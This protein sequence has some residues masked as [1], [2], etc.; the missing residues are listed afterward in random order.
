MSNVV[1]NVIPKPITSG[2]AS[3]GKNTKLS[4][5]VI[6]VVLLA[7]FSCSLYCS[8]AVRLSQNFHRP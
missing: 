7:I 4:N 1:I 5:Q 3:T 6:S 2:S 8:V